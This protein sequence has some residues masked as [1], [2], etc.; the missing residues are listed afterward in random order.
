MK[1]TNN[2]RDIDFLERKVVFRI[3]RI[4][5]WILLG[6][7]GLGFIVSFFFLLFSLFPPTKERV[8]KPELPPKVTIDL[9]EIE[10]V[11]TPPPP[12]EKK[13]AENKVPKEKIKP[14][15]PPP[16]PQE[17][18]LKAK[19][20]T[21]AS[22]FP[23]DK[24][25]WKTVYEV[26]ISVEDFCNPYKR[27]RRIRM[28]KV[29]GLD[30]Y[31]I[32]KD[33]I[34]KLYPEIEEKIDVVDELIGIISKIPVEKRKKALKAYVSLRKKKERER[35]REIARIKKY[36]ENQR[37]KAEIKY[38]AKKAKKAKTRMKA[39]IAFGVAFVSVAIWGLFLVFLAI[40]RNTRAIQ[41]MTRKVG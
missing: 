9:S 24:F 7:G 25:T 10:R 33:G 13:M 26:G 41:E 4:I 32:G 21:L 11:I 1:E 27:G 6:I 30:N 39:L 40:E 3:S 16:S 28:V 8:A 12:K 35:K 36:I 31:L 19:I 2:K 15:P 5:S 23:P 37:Y 38:L 17:V 18:A 34:L 29:W 20:D 14:T 22:Y